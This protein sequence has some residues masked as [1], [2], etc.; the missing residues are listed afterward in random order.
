MHPDISHFSHTEFYGGKALIARTPST[1]KQTP[2]FR[3]QTEPPE[4]TWIDV[5]ASKGGF[6][7]NK[8]EVMAIKAELKAF[9]DYARDHPPTSKLRDNP[10]QWEIA[11]LSPYQKQRKALVSMVQDLTGLDQFMSL[12]LMK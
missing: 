10:E 1:S 4:N 2:S 8:G 7:V 12:T 5:P 9:I 3:V 11:V 6:S